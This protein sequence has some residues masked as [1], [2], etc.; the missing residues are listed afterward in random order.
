ML[1]VSKFHD[2][3]DVGM[4]LGVDKTVV[5]DRKTTPIEGKFPCLDTAP[6]ISEWKTGVLG[7]CGKFYPFVYLASN[8][9]VD[10]IIWSMEEALS[11]IPLKKRTYYDSI[12]TIEGVKKFFSESYEQLQK[13][14]SAHRTPI[15]VFEPGTKYFYRS[16]KQ[17]PYRSLVLSP[18]LKDLEFYKVK[19]PIS[20]F[21]DVYS[22]ISGVLGMP[23]KKAKPI[24]DKVM[25]ASKGHDS[26]YSFRKPPS[27]RGKPRWR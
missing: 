8:S 26:P 19:D 23:I 27:K 13:L 5:Y 21:Q 10:R 2:Y 12:D 1:I 15:F 20:A 24:D 11:S 18:N 9:K 7:F 25:A 22:Y 6:K 17:T 4:K 14:F 16:N 3:Y